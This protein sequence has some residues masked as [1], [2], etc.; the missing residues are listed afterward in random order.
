MRTR[1]FTAL[2]V[3]LLAGAVVGVVLVDELL[4]GV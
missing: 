3:A 2:L 1:A 4:G